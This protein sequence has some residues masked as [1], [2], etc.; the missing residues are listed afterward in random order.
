MVCGKGGTSGLPR[1]GKNIYGL[2]MEGQPDGFSVGNF[3]E[4]SFTEY[5]T[6]SGKD[7]F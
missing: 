2:G 6:G 3:F 7:I 4:G 5:V 1:G